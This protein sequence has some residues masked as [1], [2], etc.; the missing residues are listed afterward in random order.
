MLLKGFLTV[1]WKLLRM[2]L[3]KLKIHLI[4]SKVESESWKRKSNR[5]KKLT[6]N[7]AKLTMI[8]NW[9]WSRNMLIIWKELLLM[10]LIS[11]TSKRENWLSSWKM[12]SKNRLVLVCKKSVLKK[13]CRSS[14]MKSPELLK[15]WSR[16]KVKPEKKKSSKNSKMIWSNSW[17]KKEK[18]L[19][20]KKLH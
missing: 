4:L 13:H 20:C 10:K 12:I 7:T 9:S 3:S 14:R 2:K 1:K 17:K 8:R 11:R 15:I 16:V 18:I 5:M 6:K 19:H